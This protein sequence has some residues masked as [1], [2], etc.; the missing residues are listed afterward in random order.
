MGRERGTLDW[1]EQGSAPL[2]RPIERTENRA[3]TSP[4]ETT[5]AARLRN[6]KNE[7]G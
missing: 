2:S 1:L 5:Q 7:M 3:K 6:A 4:S